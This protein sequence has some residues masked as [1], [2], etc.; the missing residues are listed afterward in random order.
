MKFTSEIWFYYFAVSNKNYF[1]MIAMFH[2]SWLNLIGVGYLVP[3]GTSLVDEN[4]F[5]R[6]ISTIIEKTPDKNL[7]LNVSIQLP[8]LLP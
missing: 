1:N 6:L 2:F 8:C 7:K 4:K 3:P 5:V